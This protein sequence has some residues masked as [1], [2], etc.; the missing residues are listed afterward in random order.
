MKN[1]SRAAG[2]AAAAGVLLG[3]HQSIAGG[4][5]RAV[6]RAEAI[7]ATALQIFTKNSN[8]W[9]AP[10]I[11]EPEAA[12][13]KSALSKSTL[14][15]VAA[16]DSYLINLAAADPA[17]LKK[18]LDALV[19]EIRR[20][21]ILGV[22]LLN[23]HPGA[24]VGAGEAEGIR[25]IVESLDIVHGRTAGSSVLSVLETT[26]GQ[27]STLGR[28][29]GELRAIMDGVADPERMAVCIDTCHVFAAGYDIS[30]AAGYSRTIDEFDAVVGLGRL[31]LL[32]LNDSVKGP[33]SRVDRHAHIGK[34][35]I[36]KEA[37]RLIMTDERLREVPKILETPKEEDLEEDRVNMRTLLD[38][39]R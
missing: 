5:H 39:A 8:R 37:F 38:L 13:Y 19:D 2:S 4:F 21:E 36:G 20:C 7:G 33:G 22:P 28:T 26:A 10:P 32:H 27:G 15:A 17:I 31:K 6:E 11:G 14:R 29:F 34:G 35:M 16:H 23:F 24:H 25:K 3:S 9:E 18:S 30:T 12:S 1:Q